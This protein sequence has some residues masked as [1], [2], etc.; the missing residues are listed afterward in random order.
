MTREGWQWHLLSAFLFLLSSPFV[1]PSTGAAA[2]KSRVFA[3][4]AGMRPVHVLVMDGL[5]VDRRR[6][7]SAQGTGRQA[8]ETVG[9]RFF[10]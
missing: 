6:T 3:G 4:A 9:C 2:G 10:W 8:G 5:Y 7:G 1:S